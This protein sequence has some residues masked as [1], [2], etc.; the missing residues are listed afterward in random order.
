M[1]KTPFKVPALIRN[2]YFVTT[3]A[4]IIWLAFLD[5]NNMLSQYELTAEVNKMEDQK[6]FYIENNESTRK[7]SQELLSSMEK[8]EKFAREKYKMKK[9]NEDVFLI[10]PQ[11]GK[12]E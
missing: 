9:D 12:E 10:I 11:K 5:R 1:L 4:F 3:A 7:E 2:K 8:L 6:N